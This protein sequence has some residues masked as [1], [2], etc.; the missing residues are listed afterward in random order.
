[1][2]AP[3]S[4]HT[5]T[6]AL[7]VTSEDQCKLYCRVEY[8]SAYYLLAASVEDGTPCGKDTFHKVGPEPKNI[9]HVIHLINLRF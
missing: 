2:P 1:M 9:R 7:S 6:L 8:S 5:P 4:A 3:A